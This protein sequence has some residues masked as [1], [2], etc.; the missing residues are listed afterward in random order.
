MT[1]EKK[2]EIWTIDELVSLTEKVQSIELE[3]S[4]KVLPIQWCELT[5][6]EEPKLALPEED[7]SEEDKNSHYAK[8]AS[9]RVL[10][11][12]NKAND[13]NPDGK[14][15]DNAVWE[16]LPTTLRW[17]ISNTILKTSDSENL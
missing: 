7:L 17:R 6:A 11:M 2:A 13:K 4:G 5:E 8:L 9:N 16:K 10:A 12:I 14:T 3:Y 15:V 1:T